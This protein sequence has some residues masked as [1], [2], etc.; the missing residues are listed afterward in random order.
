MKETLKNSNYKKC[1]FIVAIVVVVII[2]ILIALLVSGKESQES[3]G[4]ETEQ[5]ET[6]NDIHTESESEIETSEDASDSTEIM[7]ETESIVETESSENTEIVE[8]TEVT[9]ETE[10]T[11]T[12]EKVEE[13]E[14]IEEKEETQQ[15]ENSETENEPVEPEVPKYTFEEYSPAKIMYVKS[16]VNVRDLPEKI[17]NR[18]GSLTTNQEVTVLARCNETGWY[19]IEHNDSIAYVS[20]NYLVNEKIVIETPKPEVK[21]EPEEPEETESEEV[22]KPKPTPTKPVYTDESQ[23]DP[24]RLYFGD[25]CTKYD[26]MIYWYVPE[27]I[28]KISVENDW[29]ISGRYGGIDD[30]GNPLM[31]IYFGSKTDGLDGT[32]T[33]YY[34]YC[35]GIIAYTTEHNTN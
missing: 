32:W 27:E 22:V 13:T 5:T 3:G 6:G 12:T 34:I 30:E 28:L 9:E 19:K 24:T 10:T 20:S 8:N 31:R 25:Y 14:T 33:T 4:T 7:T 18:V 2:A 23:M 26:C 1:A 15:P 11:E 16:S 21:P 35:D 17:G 29:P